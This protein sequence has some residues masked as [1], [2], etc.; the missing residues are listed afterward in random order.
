ME[1][2]QTVQLLQRRLA[3]SPNQPEVPYIHKLLRE[4]QR[5]ALEQ[6]N[7]RCDRQRQITGLLQK[8]LS[9]INLTSKKIM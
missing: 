8:H 1:P 4:E 7:V 3:V 5:D 6:L 9:I 2:Q